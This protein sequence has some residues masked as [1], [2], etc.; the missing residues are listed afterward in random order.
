MAELRN[1]LKRDFISQRKLKTVLAVMPVKLSL[2]LRV[3]TS[4]C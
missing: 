2:Q 1:C 3:E 4:I